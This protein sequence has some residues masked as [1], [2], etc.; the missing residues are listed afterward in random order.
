MGAKVLFFYL[1]FSLLYQEGYA[2]MT[3]MA[4]VDEPYLLFFK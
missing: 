1:S 3:K 4:I 2:L